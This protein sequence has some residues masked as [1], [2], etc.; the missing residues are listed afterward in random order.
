[1]QW[2]LQHQRKHFELHIYLGSGR[3]DECPEVCN[4]KMQSKHGTKFPAIPVL[5]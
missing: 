1:M 2:N 4:I 3:M 5:K